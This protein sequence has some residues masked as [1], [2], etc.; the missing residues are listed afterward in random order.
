MKLRLQCQLAHGSPTGLVADFDNAKEL[1][2]KIASCFEGVNKDEILYCTRN[3]HR[4]DMDAVFVGSLAISDFLFAHLAGQRKEVELVKV[5]KMLGIALSDNG[6][7]RVFIR[8]IAQSSCL[9][10][11]QDAIQA[12]DHIE[13]VNGETMVGKRHVQVAAKLREIEI[14]S[15]FTLRLISPLKAGFS[16]VSGRNG[17]KSAKNPQLTNGT[18]GMQTI[19]F[20]S[21][22]GAVIEEP[23]D[24]LV[25][26]RLN[27]IFGEYLGIQD[28]ELAR[29]TLD[30][31]K[32]EECASL[33]SFETQIRSSSLA[34]FN[35]PQEF[36]FDLW[37][38]IDDYKNRRLIS[39]AESGQE[40]SDSQ[41]VNIS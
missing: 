7:G 18:D 27:E 37:G 25:L 40:Q 9:R 10:N 38:A 28:E 16:F 2:E 24:S 17:N 33:E 26:D 36:I 13:K 4:A 14:G 20:K 22:G 39:S 21:V 31:G 6:A 3:T 12:G 11:A 23:T 29:T 30:I 41:E 34:E 8:R 32:N 19:R 15:R 1:Y 35:F 5:D